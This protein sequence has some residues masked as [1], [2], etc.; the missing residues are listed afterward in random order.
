MDGFMMK[1]LKNIGAMD[2]RGY[3]PIFKL[4][5]KDPDKYCKR[6]IEKCFFSYTKGLIK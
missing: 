4:E 6:K 2:F 1:I 5:I 3:L